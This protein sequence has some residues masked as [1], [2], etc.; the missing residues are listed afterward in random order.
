MEFQADPKLGEI[1]TEKFWFEGELKDFDPTGGIVSGTVGAVY[2]LYKVYRLKK[3]DETLEEL[4]KASDY[5]TAALPRGDKII[6]HQT[7]V[8]WAR[9][10]IWR[11]ASYAGAQKGAAGAAATAVGAVAGGTVAA[12]LSIGGPLGIAAGAAVMAAIKAGTKQSL[13]R[14]QRGLV[15]SARVEVRLAT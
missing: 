14:P 10:K 13:T 11:K 1:A 9:H 6:D 8:R 3:V 2:E 12:V 15:R 7:A 4:M 5:Q